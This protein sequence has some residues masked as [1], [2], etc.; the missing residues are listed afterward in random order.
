MTEQKP[1]PTKVDCIAWV[2]VLLIIIISVIAVVVSNPSRDRF[3]RMKNIS[4]EICENNSLLYGSFSG[5][6][7]ICK[8][9]QTF[10]GEHYNMTAPVFEI[11]IQPD[12]DYYLN[13]QGDDD[14]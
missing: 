5:D 8:T 10:V 13:E 2:W 14:E 7:I 9:N 6:T 11:K 4:K 1:T 12:W 3:D